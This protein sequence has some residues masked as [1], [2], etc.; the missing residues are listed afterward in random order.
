MLRYSATWA[1]LNVDMISKSNIPCWL[2]DRLLQ[3]KPM[4]CDVGTNS[5][6]TFRN[7]VLPGG[8][9][10][11]QAACNNQ[12][13]Q[14]APVFQ[15]LWPLAEDP[16]IPRKVL[17]SQYQHPACV[18]AVS[19]QE[20]RLSWWHC[21]Q[22]QWDAF[23]FDHAIHVEWLS[24]VFK[25]HLCL[26]RDTCVNHTHTAVV[27]EALGTCTQG[28]IMMLVTMHAGLLS[29]NMHLTNAPCISWA[30]AVHNTPGWVAIKSLSNQ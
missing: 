18:D 10:E 7:V 1:H 20:G 19:V 27:F 14:D 17:C 24:F 28:W 5:W 22:G 6:W 3:A 12:P 8:G 23:S 2:T 16:L 30:A 11:W 29:C 26:H 4:F 21:S 15:A 13:W 9:K 25:V